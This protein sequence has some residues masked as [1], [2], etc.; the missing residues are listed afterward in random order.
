MQAALDLA[1]AGIKVYLLDEAPAIGGKMVQL[2]K[3]FP[4]N[5]CAMCTVSPRLVS[6]DRHL[7]I[8]LLTNSRVISCEG[9]AGNFRVN[10]LKKARFVDLSKC[11]GCNVCVEKCPAKTTSEFEHGLAK[12]KA[13]YT[14]F[15]QAVPN[16]PVIDKDN[17]IY[18]KKGKGCK[19]CE[20]F[21]EAG[22][23]L[24]D[25][26]DET[27]E[28]NVGAVVL[29]PGY[30]L[31]DAA[32]KPQ[33]GF[34]RY[35]DVLTSLQFERM[36]AA[37][38]PFAGKVV[39]PSNGELPQKV[40]FIQC[41]GSRETSADFC[42]AVCCMYATKEALILKEHHP[43]IDV[44]IFYIDLRAYGKGFESYYER[45]KKA[46]VRYIRCQPS[47][48]KQ[49][50]ASK[51]I[52]VRHQ[53]EQ[54]KIEEEKF[55]L[56]MLSCGLRPSKGSQTLADRFGIKLDSNGFCLTDGLD[57]VATSQEGVFAVGAFT[58]PKDI[59]ETVIQA[60]AAASRVMALLAEKKNELIQQRIYPEERVVDGSEPRLGVFVC[61]CGKN[62]S[63][64]VNIP[65]LVDYARTLPNVTFVDDT[66]FACSTDAGEKI[67]QSIIEHGLNR[68]IVAACTPRTHEG[69]FQD[70]L[71]E[72]GLNPYL[73]E[74]ANIRNQCSW[75]HMH[76]P[77]EA[78]YKAKDI[79][80]L[81]AVKVNHLKPL[82]PGQVPVSHEGVVIGGGLA[83]M[84]AALTLAD[85]GYKTY[86]FEKSRELG[87]NFKRVKFGEPGE[88][89]QAKLH[90]MIERIKIHP[91]V[92]YFLEASFNAF[93][94]AA[95]N[96]LIGFELDGQQRQVKAGAVIVATGASEYQPTEYLYGKDPRV[97]TQLELEERLSTEK[98]EA[99][100]VVMVQC[101][102][103]RDEKRQYC[104]RLCC[105]QAI[106]NAI[107]IKARQPET[108]VFI[109]YRDIR[110][111]SL[112]EAEYT[113]ARKLGIRFLR[114]EQFE[115]P[116]VKM[117][118][119]VLKVSTFD[120][121]LKAR[122]NVTADMLVL[123]VGVVPSEDQDVA[124][125]L[126][127]P[128]SE[129][130]FLMEAHIKLRPVDSPVEGVFLAGLAHGPKLA[131]ESIAQAG[132]A[133]AKA[134]AIL[135]K[136]ER[137]LEACVSEVLDD[138]C[139]GCAYCVEPCPFK[140]ITLIEYMSNGSVKKTAESDP[141]KCQGCGVCMAT[142]PKKGIMVK[143]FNL[144]ELSDM[145]SAVLTP[146]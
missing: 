125:L 16:V 97:L 129:D 113:R 128:Q 79:V 75:V 134:A 100:T 139:D 37:S 42:S 142:C 38:G 70:T 91:N 95:G 58:G 10:V 110:S 115:K 54:G 140:A 30:D 17:C 33:L 144:E 46:G 55:D 112:H 64:V 127:L 24:L 48:L 3:T 90:E 111:Y 5:D 32:E 18:F 41:V 65:D 108:E 40:A 68:V 135:S 84:T 45:A 9:E 137:Q 80:R 102:G 25:Q 98:I 101:V 67:K 86:L 93:E 35:P 60:G 56:V 72:A 99:K 23:I 71:R 85:S 136:D 14:P 103:S 7:N 78:T 126:K 94:G 69:L 88:E 19:A 106:K 133:A 28:I 143:N 15:A 53:D 123:S 120:P 47:S 2:D 131:D 83:G 107:K 62:I 114:Y 116:V 121:I 51:E 74:M 117:E 145:V 66:L 39:R 76:Q 50:P 12:R 11:T 22:A 26:Q 4:T 141:A 36:L 44:A 34:G 43:E 118:A 52:I 119:G 81:A 59:P 96:F 77:A 20:K 138:N 146:A 132:A 73:L 87:G 104:S 13:I 109:L 1:E 61:H 49:I 63:S 124:K 6:I 31:F 29:A 122:L 57:P 130:G 89:P 8:E 92:E 105:I 27:V 82:R 21:C